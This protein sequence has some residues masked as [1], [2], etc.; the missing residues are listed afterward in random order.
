[1]T[2]IRKYITESNPDR[3]K[4]MRKLADHDRFSAEKIL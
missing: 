2:M 4:L 1:M 3:S